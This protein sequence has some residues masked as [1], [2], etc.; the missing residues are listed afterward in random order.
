MKK[1]ATQRD[2][3]PAKRDWITSMIQTPTTRRKFLKTAGIGG[4]GMLAAYLTGCTS[5]AIGKQDNVVIREINVDDAM[6]MIIGIT[7]RCVG[8]RRCEHACIEYNEG[9]SQP[10]L[11]RINIRRNWAFG[12]KGA[13]IGYSH[14]EG[15]FG[16]HRIIQET[17]RQCGHPTPCALACPY[18][19][20]ETVPPV[21]ARVVNPD[22]C[23]GCRMCVDAC[24]WGMI[25]FDEVANK[26]QKCFL[27]NNDP[28]CVQACPT[29]ALRYVPWE[30][31]TKIIPP[32]FVISAAMKTPD[33]IECQTADC[34][35]TFG[36]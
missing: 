8:C 23:Q 20:I 26:A 11:A 30:D 27:C 1:P 22:K 17:C 34:H 19:A 10:S 35:P 12:P 32:R 4:L 25:T 29:G 9:F 21:N 31:L 14:A 24:P 3:T 15:R 36:K 5:L 7:N 13:Q 33:D 2:L 18:N 28:Q 16:N 6:G